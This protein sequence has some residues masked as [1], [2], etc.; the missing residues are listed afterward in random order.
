MRTLITAP[1]P[2]LVA[3]LWAAAPAIQRLL[4][5]A[6]SLHH[7]RTR[8]F[9]HLNT[10]ERRYF[11]VD[12]DPHFK[13]M[14]IAE[15]HIAKECIR[16]MKN[17]IRSENEQIT[18]TSALALLRQL[19]RRS[20]RA[21]ASVS[22][23]FL[24]EC[25]HLF[26]GIYGRSGT[27]QRVSDHQHDEGT[28]AAARR[29]SRQL[30]RYAQAAHDAMRRY[31]SGLE[32]ELVRRS[33]ALRRR[34]LRR[35]DAGMRQW[36]DPRWQLA[37]VI[38][39]ADTLRALVR[40]EPDE[41]EG[42]AAAKAHGIPFHVTPYY[43]TLFN[44]DGRDD[45][46]RAVRAQVI[47]SAAYCRTVAANR[48]QGVDLDFMG[49]RSTSPIA[50][51]TRRYPHIVIL[52]PYDACPQIC[53]YCQ[54][55]WE[56][57]SL[58]DA[59]VT[60][61]AVQAA[62]QWL[63]RHPGITEV[64]L[65]GGDPLTLDD[66][67]L[68]WILDALAAMPH[69]DRIRIGTRTLVTMPQRFTPALVRLLARHHVLGRREIC[70]MTH[71]ESPRELTPDVLAAVQALRRAG[72]SIYNQQVFTYY[73]SRRFETAFLRRM[74]KRCGIDPYYTF[75]TKGKDETLDFRVPIARLE[76]ERKEEARQ[77]P[78]VVRTDEPVFNVPR[79]GKSHLRSWQD[80]EPLML[81]P[82]GRRVYRFFPWEARLRTVED[83]IYT[84][85][86]IYDYLKR[87]H[88][89]GENVDDYHS[90]WYYF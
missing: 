30:D 2:A 9:N 85:V 46:D 73:T 71:V 20:P 37:H 62:L 53:V 8:L 5:S 52:K 58:D 54:R 41:I 16:V 68:R 27:L 4:A 11:S 67:Y 13:D 82:D 89:D 57:K 3:A 14:P 26:N 1:R 38:R 84:D 25:L 35:F 72:L 86:S 32:P 21:C 88:A 43:V 64:L 77:L 34:V 39:D 18:G 80:H 12:A 76:Q 69:V 6:R 59:R 49:E 31:H 40:L 24:C 10:L 17:I 87:L 61:P 22:P 28:A 83:Y 29:R 66:R 50:G 51:I 48:A 45:T 79:I 78:G 36:R 81:L 19:A 56:I 75:N 60:R 7:A 33:A 23:G 63:A 90:I 74:L 42:L 44:P 55:N 70:I 15:K 65:T 47:P